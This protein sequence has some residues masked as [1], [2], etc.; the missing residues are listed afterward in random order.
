MVERYREINRIRYETNG[1]TE[2]TGPADFRANCRAN[3]AAI[4]QRQ[5]CVGRTMR[6]VSGL[7]GA[8][9]TH[10]QDGGLLHE[11]QTPVLQVPQLRQHMEGH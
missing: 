10:E 2:E 7:A 9:R 5:S 6:D 4:R 11:R 3:D 8:G 1:K